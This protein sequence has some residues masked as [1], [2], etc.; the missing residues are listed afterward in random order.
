MTPVIGMIA[1]KCGWCGE[2][3]VYGESLDQLIDSSLDENHF[4]SLWNDFNN[5]KCPKC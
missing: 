2:T 5:V 1:G 3:H 4:R